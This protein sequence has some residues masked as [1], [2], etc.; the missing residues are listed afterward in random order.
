MNCPKCIGKLQKRDMSGV[1]V[2][3]CYV[4]EGIWFDT[5]ELEKLLK[6]D[7]ADFHFDTL[8]SEDFDAQEMEE[9]KK[10]L[11][12]KPGKCPRCDDD[13]LLERQKSPHTLKELYVDFCPN[14]HGVWL[15]GGEIHLLRRRTLVN[16][17][18]WFSD[19]KVWLGENLN[20]NRYRR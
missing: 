20:R 18:D 4:C 7:S 1:E 12:T 19:V 14:N 16:L 10:D 2:D 9:V 17:K 11:D 5:G 15:D 3:V 6:A 8:A 13:T